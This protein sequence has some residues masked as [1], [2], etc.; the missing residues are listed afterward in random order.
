MGSD[1]K[2]TNPATS[3]SKCV[4][5]SHKIKKQNKL[6]Q[7]KHYNKRSADNQQKENKA[8]MTLFD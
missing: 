7:S 6:D 3:D 5:N 8:C 2:L 1:S 4:I